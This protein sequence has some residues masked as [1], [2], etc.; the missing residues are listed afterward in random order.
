MMEKS[1]ESAFGQERVFHA[2]TQLYIIE[3]FNVSSDS[4]AARIGSYPG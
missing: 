4:G 2:Y 3:P 1:L